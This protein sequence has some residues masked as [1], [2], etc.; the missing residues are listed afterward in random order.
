MENEELFERLSW[1]ELII[2]P[3]L[4][5][6]SSTPCRRNFDE[7]RKPQLLSVAIGPIIGSST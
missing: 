4:L 5:A 1:K 2:L 6:P 7:N 3:T